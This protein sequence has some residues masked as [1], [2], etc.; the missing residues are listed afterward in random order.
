MYKENEPLIL[1]KGVGREGTDGFIPEG[2]EVIFVR[3]IENRL[4]M[5]KPLVVFQYKDKQLAVPEIAVKPTVTDTISALEDVN[6]AMMDNDPNLKLYHHNRFMR[7]LYITLDWIK[8]KIINP[9]ASIRLT[10]EKNSDIN[11]K[12]IVEELKALMED[13]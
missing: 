6:K 8:R 10:R 2:T 5:F 3:I 9:I 11:N 4:D 12:E 7:V 13:E 1:T